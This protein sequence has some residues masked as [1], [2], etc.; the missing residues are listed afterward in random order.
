[1]RN[2]I[3]CWLLACALA[4]ASGA[5][6]ATF[7][8]FQIREIYSDATGTVQYIVLRES[9]DADGQNLFTTHNI[10]SRSGSASLSVPFPENL[11][12][13][14]TA[15]KY[16][17]IGTQSFAALGLIAPDYVVPD[18][19]VHLTIGL[20]DFAGVD[21]FGYPALPTDG[22]SALFRDG[23][24]G[25][26]L[27]TNFAGA[28]ASVAGTAG[29]AT[30]APAV[31]YYYAAWDYYFMTAFPA[32]IA[33]LDG[34]AFGGVWKRT[35]E[36]FNVWPAATATSSV[37]CRFFSTSFAPKSSHF[38][39]PFANECA[40]VKTNPDWEYENDAF[41]IQLANADGTCPSGTI[42]LYRQYNNGMGGAPNHRY[43]TSLTVF[44]AMAAA[45][46][47][48]EG[49]GNTK[50]FACVPP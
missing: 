43:T 3:S 7:H 35:G 22:V 16:V 37:T 44:N 26:N 30:T 12:N 4:L 41:Y 48:F 13:H 47:V 50:V 11:P 45:G 46:W 42:P 21:A 17:L 38:Y 27:A 39:T 1:M 14:Q 18:G 2:K 5:A 33:T 6:F 34:G 25:P 28:T 8:T 9:E 36:S 10:T 40:G 31:E 20:I 49:D 29:P 23:T 15:G 19:F 32:E 24:T